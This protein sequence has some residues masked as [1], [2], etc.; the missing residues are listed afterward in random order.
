MARK[1]LRRLICA[2]LLCATSARMLAQQRGAHEGQEIFATR[3]ATCHGL[4]GRGGERGP[5]IA[6]RREVQQLS[7]KALLTIVREGIPEAG[8]PS[9]RALGGAKIAVVVQH[10]RFLQGRDVAVRMRGDP[11][12]GKV[13]FSGKAGCAECHTVNSEGGFLGP[14]LSCYAN[15]QSAEEI[16]KAIT[17]PNKNLDPRFRTVLVTTADGTTSTGIAR[18]ED[19]FSLQ[20][21]TL[22]G[23]YHSFTKSE[24]RS[25]EH[26]PRSL[27]PADYG[28]KLTRG[29]IDDVVSY[30]AKVARTHPKQKFLKNDN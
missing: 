22:D 9:F 21:Q 3:C 25:V 4:D 24:L 12:R 26:Q 11:E 18:N 2:V 13:L 15:T 1:D 5:N 7:D 30:L 28:S 16:R 8:M 27:M 14:D 19:N 29:E 23:A 6:R 17:D 10:L 20:L